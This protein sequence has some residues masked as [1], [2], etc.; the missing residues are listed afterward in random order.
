MKKRNVRLSKTIIPIS[1]DITIEPSEDMQSYNGKII[2]KAKII[3]QTKEIILHAKE[4]EIKNA[5]ICVGT[6]CLLPQIKI[7]KEA[8]TIILKNN[9]LIPAGEIEIH[10]EF[11]GKITDGLNGIYR[12]KYE[13]EGKTNYLIT[14]Q[15]EAPYARKIFPC[16]DEPDKKA[17][18]DISVII[19]QNLKAISNMSIKSE[20]TEKNK[21][22]IQF[23]TT[24]KMSSYL[25]YLGIGNFEFLEDNY[26][27]VKLRLITT[28]GKSK[29]GKFALEHTKK[30][31]EYFEKYS[32]IDYPLEKLDL[33]AIPDFSAGAMENWGAITFRELILLVDEKNT[34][35]KIKKRVAEVIAHEL[36]H[37]WSGN[38]VTMNWWND[39]WLNES[40]ANYMAYKAVAQYNPDWNMWEDYLSN[41]FSR[42]MFKDTL[43][44]THA[45]EVEV[46][47]P[48][49]IEEIF[50]EISYSKGGS[51]LRM[52]EN[53]VGEE[54]FRK[55][56]SSYLKKH[57][58]GNAEAQDLWKAISK[59]IN[60]KKIINLMKSWISQPGYP[61]LTIKRKENN[62]AITQERCNKK[63]NQIWP[64]P[65]SISSDNLNFHK[66]MNKRTEFYN[67]KSDNLK[68]NHEQYGVYRTKY[69]LNSLNQLSILI[70]NKNL[71]TANRW[72]IQNDLWALCNIGKE[73]IANYIKF[74]ENY[75]NEESLIILSDI[76]TSIKKLDKLFIKDKFWNKRK[77]NLLK[78]IIP[79]YKKIIKK[80]GWNSREQESM[81]DTLLRSLAISFC[82][83]AEDSETLIEAKKRYA[84]NEVPINITD[85]VYY[86]IARTGNLETFDKM[87][88]QYKNEKDLERKTKLL[89]ALYQFKQSDIIKKALDLAI[90]EEV[91]TQDLRYC[92]SS[93][94]SNPY[95][96]EITKFWIKK[97]W[98]KLKKYESYYYVFEG[99]LDAIILTQTTKK[100]M[101]EV[102][103]FLEKNKVKYERTKANAFEILDMNI[104]LIK[105]NND[106][107]TQK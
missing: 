43:K 3:K 54:N 25:F 77:D 9:N 80:L 84:K 46:N 67:I 41:E 94:I 24:P 45:I 14:T 65:I 79:S 90:S 12:S 15:C 87:L 107:L 64:I 8:E 103:S 36:W 82:G 101:Q 44:S 5:T 27:N 102:K 55:G 73:K 72:G 92:F 23:K 16:F 74:L 37:Q 51:V 61:L 19:Y 58:Y 100:A 70:K 93:L 52:L 96:S 30:Y 99:I 7:K 29:N 105:N 75:K 38:L 68:I 57:E 66:L 22:K 60:D 48:N 31:L 56:V 95:I 17:T 97:N 50:D 18:F 42:G 40:F 4:L 35:A 53:Y 26:K 1:Y 10:S 11:G 83:F 62:I 91:R 81:E 49:E 6:K 33:I 21:K 59:T 20:I 98:T 39:L 32:E 28:P 69:D 76:A 85:A 89:V 34:S 63:T 104:N 2:I 88:D 13:Y 106:F 47:S 78:E 71:S 86:I